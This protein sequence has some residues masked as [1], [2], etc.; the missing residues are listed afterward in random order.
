M[1]LKE[2]LDMQG[3][4]FANNSPTDVKQARIAQYVEI[5]KIVKA[6]SFGIAN[7]SHRQGWEW[8]GEGNPV[9]REVL[10]EQLAT[11]F[12][13]VLHE[14]LFYG[15]DPNHEDLYSRYFRIKKP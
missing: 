3:G 7:D 9:N 5:G 14:Y 11:L 2:L 1:T 13:L 6:I 15:Y 10:L 4:A 8:R 12:I